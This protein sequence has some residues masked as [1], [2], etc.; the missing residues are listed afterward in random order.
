M[1][2]IQWMSHWR[3]LFHHIV[4][5]SKYMKKDTR[6]QKNHSA[7]WSEIIASWKYSSVL[8][9]K[10]TLWIWLKYH[11]LV[12]GQ[13]DIFTVVSALKDIAKDL[14]LIPWSFLLDQLYSCLCTIFN[15][16]IS[17]DAQQENAELRM[18]FKKR[19]LHEISREKNWKKK[20]SNL[21][22]IFSKIFTAFTN[23]KLYVPW[24]ALRI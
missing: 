12:L 8:L 20:K 1:K 5:H 11:M 17:E 21:K 10:S 18:I 13:L 4:I 7:L 23:I 22:C 19:V 6:R 9:K 16:W 14:N 24:V 3:Y 15:P 2:W